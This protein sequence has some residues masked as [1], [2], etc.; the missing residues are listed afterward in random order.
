MPRFRKIANDNVPKFKGTAGSTGESLRVFKQLLD[1][2]A[3]NGAA[4]Q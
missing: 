4:A 3:A 2:A 1:D